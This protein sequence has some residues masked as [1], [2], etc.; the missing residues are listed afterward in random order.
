MREQRAR[1]TS[2]GLA[3]RLTEIKSALEEIERELEEGGALA[4]KASRI[5]RPP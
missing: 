1:E 4:G 2:K 5:S 3:E